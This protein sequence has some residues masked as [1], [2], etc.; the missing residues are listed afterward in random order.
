MAVN[1]VLRVTSDQA[2]QLTATITEQETMKAIKDLNM[3]GSPRPDGIQV[4]FY[5]EMWSVIAKEVMVV[6]REFEKCNAGF[7]KIN[8]SYLFLL[9][10]TMGAEKFSDFRPISL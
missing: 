3:E 10:K 6:I 2:S 8:K 9:P 5:K 7:N 1:D 4:F